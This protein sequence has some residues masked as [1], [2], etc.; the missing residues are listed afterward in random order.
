M[1]RLWHDFWVR[2]ATRES[3]ALGASATVLD[4]ARAAGASAEWCK[5]GHGVSAVVSL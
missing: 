1:S 5:V 3:L 2:S 4:M